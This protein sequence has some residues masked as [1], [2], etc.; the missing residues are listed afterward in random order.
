MVRCRYVRIEMVDI[1]A[2]AVGTESVGLA[3]PGGH[4][5]DLVHDLAYA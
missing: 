3:Y 2:A 4:L 5:A 1:R